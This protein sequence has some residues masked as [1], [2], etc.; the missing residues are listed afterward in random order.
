MGSEDYERYYFGVDGTQSRASGLPQHDADSGFQQ[1]GLLGVFDYDLT[2][3]WRLSFIGR[4][5]RMV[6]DAEDSP[7]VDG[8]GGRGSANQWAGG[9]IVSYGW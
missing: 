5:M 3:N 1:V 2:N 6:G 4:Y 9:A 8:D 7:L